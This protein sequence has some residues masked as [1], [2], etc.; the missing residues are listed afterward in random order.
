M[1]RE[2]SSEILDV[3]KRW[4]WFAIVF[5][6]LLGIGWGAAYLRRGPNPAMF[7]EDCQA[8]CKPR[9]GVI[10]RQ[11]PDVNSGWRSGSHSLK[12]VCR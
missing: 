11:G 2:G 9:R 12:C 4:H 1:P 7:L 6:M 10:E 5:V 8:Y 3:M